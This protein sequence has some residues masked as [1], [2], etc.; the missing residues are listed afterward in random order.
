YPGVL[1]ALG[2]V[3]ADFRHDFLQTINRPLA[4]LDLGD[5]YGILQEQREQ[6]R[7]LLEAEGIGAA[8]R[9]C[10]F[11]ADMQYEGQIYAIRVSLPEQQPAVDALRQAFLETYRR[12]YGHVSAHLP[13]VV[14]NLRTTVVGQRERLAP[15]APSGAGPATLDEARSGERPVYFEG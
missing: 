14:T 11:A 15:R 12:E 13:I 7:R 1:S 5:S 4:E 6:G 8:A 9:G 10:F 3:L 2:C